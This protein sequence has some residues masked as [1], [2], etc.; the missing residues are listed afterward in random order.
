MAKR[1]A[2]LFA[3]AAL[4]IGGSGPVFAQEGDRSVP[5]AELS[6]GYGFLRD[7][8]LDEN[9]PAGWYFSAAG[10]LTRWF[11]V[12]GEVTG[13]RKTFDDMQP[14][15]TVKG[16]I[17][18]GM[19]GP[20]FF[21]K[22]GRFVPYGQ[23]L[24]GAAHVRASSSSILGNFKDEDTYFALQPGGGVLVYLNSRIGAQVSADYRWI[25]PAADDRDA[26]AD[27]FRFLTGIVV[28]FGSR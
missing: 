9:V 11:G 22:V 5:A 7:F 14:L 8:D 19:A 3:A 28:G 1:F 13:S 23:M 2:L 12:V 16:S 21:T 27:E 24:V 25:D 10:N 20:R 26:S 4:L 18:T 15:A 6:G 17:Y